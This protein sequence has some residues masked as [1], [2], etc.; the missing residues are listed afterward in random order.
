M[1]MADTIHRLSMLGSWLS[2][3]WM[4]P[5]ITQNTQYLVMQPPPSA[6]QYVSATFCMDVAPVML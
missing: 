1:P 6:L 3:S 4:P 2:T 5:K